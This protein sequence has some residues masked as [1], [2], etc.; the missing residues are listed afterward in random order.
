MACAA[1]AGAAFAG[2]AFAA[3]G[4]ADGEQE[5][6]MAAAAADALPG[7]LGG[8]WPDDRGV[9]INAHGGGLLRHD[10]AYYW[11][12]E[13]KV[14]GRR[15][16]TAQV[17]VHCYA[18]EDLQSWTDRGVALAVSE[19]PDSPIVRGSVIERPKVIHNPATGKFVM[20]FHLELRGRGYDAAQTGVAVS[21]APAGPYRFL[22]ALRPN[23][24][25]W[26]AGFPESDRRPVEPGELPEAWSP[27]WVEQVRAGILVRRDVD[28]GQMAR[29]MT[30]YVDEDGTAYHIHA[31]EENMTLHISE[32][33][34]DFL[35]FT[36]QYAR[37]LPGDQN[38]APALF[39]RDGRY[40]L[41]SSGCTG[42]A[43]NAARIAVADHILGPYTPLGNPCRGINPANGMGP[44][45]T[46][47][48][49]STFIVPAPG[50]AGRF[51][52]MFD[53]WRPRNPID[54][55]Y[56]WLPIHFEEDR[57]VIAYTAPWPLGDAASP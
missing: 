38:E 39:K 20:W 35:S 1:V 56:L 42:W 25:Q 18:S 57:P 14:E 7:H 15:G 16:N 28:G 43:P 29:D 45:L 26:P 33:A 40:Y 4:P 36:G 46:F 3:A 54:G 19:D 31:A 48:A 55:R 5:V 22:G 41:L 44:D 30:L 8:V 32:L 49:Q 23:A 47:G 37:I 6:S 9:H 11:F 10:G 24:G 53:L 2:A 12:G 34:P 17:G 21:D 13:H 52:A 50:A 27:G 51:I